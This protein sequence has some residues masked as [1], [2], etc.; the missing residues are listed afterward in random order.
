MNITMSRGDGMHDAILSFLELPVA[1][2]CTLFL[3]VVLILYWIFGKLALRLLSLV[4]WLLK[5]LFYGLY[6]LIGITVSALHRVFGGIFGKIDQGL[7]NAAERLCSFCDK[8]NEKM[9]KPKTMF[10]GRAFLIFLALGAYLIIPLIL[11][12]NENIFTFWQESYLSREAS[13]IEFILSR[14]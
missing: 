1:V 13:V 5:K 7:A 4:P 6:C 11:E 9:K 10:N 3:G 2:R 12:L 14:L 8:F